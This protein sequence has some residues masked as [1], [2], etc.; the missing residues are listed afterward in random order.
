MTKPAAS[1]PP[2]PTFDD[3]DKGFI[4]GHG[5]IPLD[6]PAQTF[7]LPEQINL[8]NCYHCGTR[9]FASAGSVD[10]AK[11]PDLSPA[12]RQAAQDEKNTRCAVCRR[13]L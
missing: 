10:L 1:P 13:K 4:L 12:S 9:H 6:A 7:T 11:V 5:I 2:A 3:L 8:K